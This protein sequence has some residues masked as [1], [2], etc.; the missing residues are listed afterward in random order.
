MNG[1]E[2]ER[3]SPGML[4]WSKAGHDTGRL[5][6]IIKVEGEYVFLADGIHKMVAQPKK[7]NR[8]H[9][10]HMKKIPIS[11]LNIDPNTVRDEEIKYT[12]KAYIHKDTSKRITGQNMSSSIEGQEGENVESRCD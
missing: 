10:Q 8:K 12:I 4:A 5:Y 1:L 7:K 3:I 9:I 11:M 6:V 2:S